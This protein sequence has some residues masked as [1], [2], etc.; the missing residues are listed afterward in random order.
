MK[1]IF[2]NP[3]ISGS[4]V[5]FLGTMV[6]NFGNY[7]YH[8]L[9]GRM[10]GPKDYGSLT[11]LIS[12]TYFFS[13]IAGTFLTTT[14]KFVTK[15][16]VKKDFGKILGLFL[17]LFKIF[18]FIGIFLMILIII[19]KEKISYFLN[20]ED[21]FPLI[22]LSFW[23]MISLV[24]F[25]NDGI[26]RAFLKFGFLSFNSV[27][28]TILK[29]ILVVFLVKRGFGINGALGGIVIASLVYFLISFFPLK[30]LWRYQDKIEKINKKEFF[31]FSFPVLIA[32]LSLTSFYSSDV[33]LVKH[34]FSAMEAGIYSAVSVLGKIVFFASGVIPAVMFPLVS[35]RFE[36]G[37]S[38]RH[39]LNQSLLIVGGESIFITL[40]YF[41][42]PTLMVRLLYGN[43]YL[44]AVP[45]LGA[46]AVFISF[47]SLNNLLINFFLSVGKTKVVL[48]CLGGAILQIILINLFHSSLMEVIRI[49]LLI[50]VLLFLILMI[51]LFKNEKR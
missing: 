39:L 31:G 36:N 48:W 29:L 34:F 25:I 2:Q 6:T 5:L 42:F 16:K 17:N 10:L 20:L 14:V 45:Y 7:L 32:M 22:I 30:F 44:S 8:L 26:L 46:F 41:L 21:S 38:Y 28:T 47:Y 13:I 40:V 11:A 4:A 3:L 24:S 15:Y 12:L 43:S 50:S 49:S 35:E 37:K 1:K 19:L 18:G 23:L 9:M 27:L 51:F 33:I